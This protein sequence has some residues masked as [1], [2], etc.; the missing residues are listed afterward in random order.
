VSWRLKALVWTLVAAALAAL[1][2]FGL[3]SQRSSPSGRQAPA[4]PRERLG[5]PPAALPGSHQR[6]IAGP[7]LVTFW[8]S[9]CG[10]CAHEAP[11]LERFSRSRAGR[12]RLIGVN[13]SD[14]LS[15]ARG[16]I[17]R[18]RWSF[19]D[20]RDGDGTVGNDYRITALPTTFL[21]DSSGRIR[22]VLRGPQD[23][24]SLARALASLT[25]S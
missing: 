16:F 17:R 25:R 2:V 22:Q 12:G 8:A 4:L 24:R 23:E 18:Y 13:W 14:T 9:W 6:A 10:P 21:L 19:S 1:A 15:G 3:A 5:G 11:A 20:V 7:V